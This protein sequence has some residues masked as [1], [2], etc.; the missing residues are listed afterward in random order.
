MPSASH[1]SSSSK[2]E[3]RVGDLVWARMK[4]FSWWPSRIIEPKPEIKIPA[5]AKLKTH[6]FCFFF[7]SENFAWVEADRIA[8]YDENREKLKPAKISNNLQLAID[9][10]EAAVVG[11]KEQTSKSQSPFIQGRP[12]MNVDFDLGGCH[13]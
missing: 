9:Q 7:G 13:D 10:I 2:R 3:L 12:R 1:V 4:R 5:A 8:G 11:Y 6:N